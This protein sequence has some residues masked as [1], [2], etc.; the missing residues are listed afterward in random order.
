MTIPIA[1]SMLCVAKSWT[2]LW[3]LLVSWCNL[4]AMT[5]SIRVCHACCKTD[6]APADAPS[7]HPASATESR[8]VDVVRLLSA[9]LED[10]PSNR[11]S[12]LQI[13]GQPQV[14]LPGLLAATRV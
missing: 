9:V 3:A 6:N 11:Q 1:N 4:T 5:A 10:S 13:S 7:S 2:L 8:A 12:M 14:K